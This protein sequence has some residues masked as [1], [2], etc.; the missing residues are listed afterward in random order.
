M[1][2]YNRFI[3][4]FI[5]ILLYTSTSLAEAQFDF[6]KTRWGMT[7]DEVKASETAKIIKESKFF[8]FMDEDGL[9]Y[10]DKIADMDTE[11]C[12]FFSNNS[13]IVAIYRFDKFITDSKKDSSSKNG[14]F[15]YNSY[16]LKLK[17]MLTRQHGAPVD[18]SSNLYGKDGKL[19]GRTEKTWETDK[20][21]ITLE[22]ECNKDD[23]GLLSVFYRENKK[24]G[25][26]KDF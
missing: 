22:L 10:A 11:I 13:L 14:F 8:D 18:E 1:K 2:V 25:L 12:Y 20:T 23:E 3:S 4:S 7:R 16:H 24:T 17:D 5:V 9:V 19:F 21:V 15:T 6:R 26:M